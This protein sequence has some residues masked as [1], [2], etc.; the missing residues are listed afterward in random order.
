MHRRDDLPHQHAHCG[1]R[2]AEAGQ[3]EH[4]H[5][6]HPNAGF[7]HEVDGERPVTAMGLQET[8]VE[9]EED[10]ERGGGQDGRNADPALL[11]E[12]HRH[13]VAADEHHDR[14]QQDEHRPLAVHAPRPAPDQMAT[15]VLVPHGHPSHHGDHDGGPRHGEDQVQPRQ[16]VEDAVPVRR[17]EAGQ[18]HREHDTGAVGQDAGHGQ[19]SRL[20]EAGAHGVDTGTRLRVEEQLCAEV[21]TDG[22]GRQRHGGRHGLDDDLGRRRL[23]RLRVRHTWALAAVSFSMP[24]R[25]ISGRICGCSSCPPA[26]LM[27][28]PS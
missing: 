21:G 10:E 3:H 26:G 2:G 20:Q 6:G 25:A 13:A 22:I 5:G 11:V 9:R 27:W 28:M 17:Q 14:P 23:R 7:Q 15:A 1:T 8:A 19:R 18:G 16:L 4:E 12:Q 24:I